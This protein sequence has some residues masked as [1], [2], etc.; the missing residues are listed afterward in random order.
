MTALKWKRV[1]AAP[2]KP[3]A[4]MSTILITL[5]SSLPL[6]EQG[7]C[8][9]LWSAALRI[10]LSLSDYSERTVAAS[11]SLTGSHIKQMHMAVLWLVYW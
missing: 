9:S 11:E 6:A 8:F 7:R 4:K 10:L 3:Q 2:S 1:T 5:F